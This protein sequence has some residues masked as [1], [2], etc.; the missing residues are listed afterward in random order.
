MGRPTC[1]DGTVRS[2]YLSTAS[3]S[4]PARLGSARWTGGDSQNSRERDVNVKPLAAFHRRF[5]PQ[6]AGD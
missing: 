2:L 3:G 1:R 4:G 5:G 6:Q